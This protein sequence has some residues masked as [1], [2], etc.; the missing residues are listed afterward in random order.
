[1]LLPLLWL[2]QVAAPS[3][4]PPARPARPTAERIAR[5]L[6]SAQPAP[7]GTILV[8][9]LG[10]VERPLTLTVERDGAIVRESLRAD[11]LV[12]ALGGALT[13]DTSG[14]WRLRLAGVTLAL[15]HG[16]PFV[17]AGEGSDARELTLVHAAHAEGDRLWLPVQLLADVLPRM[18]PEFSWDAERRAF[19]VGRRP[20]P[21]S[22]PRVVATREPTLAVP[23][24]P[25]EQEPAAPSAS[26]APVP[27]P[28]A[29]D[30]APASVRLPTII[31]PRRRDPAVDAPPAARE[32][33]VMAAASASGLERR[34]V[35]VDA[36]HGGPDGGCA[37]P[38]A[39]ARGWS[40]RP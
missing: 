10:G 8:R 1:M 27:P 19:S 40:R 11:Q 32:P 9:A 3:T 17:V 18:A 7:P 15:R 35:V 37:G 14:R 12:T 4:Q 5:T 25:A 13:E 6:G 20:P 30:S 2:L 39:T 33:A 28:A 24:P 26:V 21:G 31:G 23:A 22:T 16:V 29:P 34:L 38:S 36:G